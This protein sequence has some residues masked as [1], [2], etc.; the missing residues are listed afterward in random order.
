[1]VTPELGTV[2]FVGKSGRQYSL[3]IYASDVVGAACT[4]NTVGIAVSGGQ[5]FYITPEDV[6]IKDVSI[7]TGMT[8]A[9]ALIPY[10]NDVPAGA[11]LSVA[12]CINTLTNRAIPNIG[13][14]AGKKF[15]LIQA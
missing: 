6:V 9:T 13:I 12:N 7:T 10:V 8:V 11:M 1:M 14:G 15:T 5:S 4:I 2:I 3:S